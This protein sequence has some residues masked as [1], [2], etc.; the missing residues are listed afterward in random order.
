MSKFSIGIDIH[1][2]IDT[3]P[4]FFAFLTDSVIKNGGDVHILTGSHWTPE[5]QDQLNSLGI[6]WTHK[7]SIYD[8]LMNSGAKI[9]GQVRFSDDTVQ[10]EFLKEDW[11]CVK[12]RYCKENN[13]SLHIDDGFTYKDHFTTPFAMLWSNKEKPSFKIKN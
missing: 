7:Y 8:H 2:V 9:I 12:G 3:M 10:N 13:I 11:D 1:G 6:K 4:D 5:M